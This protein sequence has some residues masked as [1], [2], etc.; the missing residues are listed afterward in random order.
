M[1]NAVFLFYN[2]I[3]DEYLKRTGCYSFLSYL[4]GFTHLFIQLYIT[5]KDTL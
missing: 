2:M 1:G 5:T 3:S 4:V